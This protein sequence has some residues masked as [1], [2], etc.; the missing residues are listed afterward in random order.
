MRSPVDGV[1]RS[2]TKD[3]RC[4]ASQNAMM[5]QQKHGEM[6]TR[7]PFACW[8]HL[9]TWK[10]EKNARC[11]CCFR[12]DS[13]K[14]LHHVCVKL[15]PLSSDPRC[16]SRLPVPLQAPPVCVAS[17]SFTTF[18]SNAG[19]SSG[20]HLSCMTKGRGSLRPRENAQAPRSSLARLGFLEPRGPGALF[21]SGASLCGDTA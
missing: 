9:D 17:S 21:G 13:P 6:T 7:D 10:S 2:E 16:S 8:K 18:L 11:H 14:Y 3:C 5:G 19:R 12:P 15:V 20:P 4:A 1:L